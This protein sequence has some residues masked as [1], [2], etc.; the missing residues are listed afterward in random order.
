MYVYYSESRNRKALSQ[1]SLHQL[2]K[3]RILYIEVGGH[4]RL[5]RNII[6]VLLNPTKKDDSNIRQTYAE[7][8]NVLGFFGE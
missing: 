2:D 7:V 6:L 3:E 1:Y 8:S 5:E 4:Y